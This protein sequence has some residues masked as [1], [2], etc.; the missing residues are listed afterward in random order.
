METLSQSI[1]LIN[2]T[3]Y[4][5]FQCASPLICPILMMESPPVFAI[6]AGGKVPISGYQDGNQLT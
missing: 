5:T 1:S 4:L 6:Q 2:V 3:F